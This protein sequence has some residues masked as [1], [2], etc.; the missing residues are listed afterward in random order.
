MT[1]QSDKHVFGMTRPIV[2]GWAEKFTLNG[3][4]DIDMRAT[5]LRL[6][7]PCA[8]FIRIMRLITTEALRVEFSCR[9][10]PHVCV[11]RLPSNLG[12]D[13]WEWMQFGSQAC[14][15]TP[16]HIGPSHQRL[17]VSDVRMQLEYTGL[18]PQG[19]QVGSRLDVRVMMIGPPDG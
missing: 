9:D 12:V 3:T 13:P 8:G 10:D 16:L 7:V 6:V 5:Q 2:L 19:L 17:N 1:F 15:I 18:I 4:P 14:K 11:G